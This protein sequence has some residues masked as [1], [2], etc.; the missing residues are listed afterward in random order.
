M[1][2]SHTEQNGVVIISLSGKIMGGPEA[3]E[4]YD[5]FNQLLDAKKLKII[6]DLEQV[7]WMNSSG[8]GILIQASTLLRNNQ[9]RLKLVNVSE[10][11]QN[12]LK[13]TKLSG[14]FETSGSIEEAISSLNN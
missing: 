9:G 1:N 2:Y 11:I 13:I 14:I 12:L 10:R 4:I 7:E 3:T 8:L 6:I 5:K